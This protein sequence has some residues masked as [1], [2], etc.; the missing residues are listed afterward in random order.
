MSINF[1][2]SDHNRD[3]ARALPDL[4]LKNSISQVDDGEPSAKE[5][6]LQVAR[7]RQL[8]VSKFIIFLIIRVLTSKNR[9]PNFHL[10]HVL[11]LVSL[12]QHVVLRLK[13]SHK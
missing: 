7:K 6:R 10:L 9:K 2:T 4:F 1:I 12:V 13:L 5:N 8:S 11:G 3:N